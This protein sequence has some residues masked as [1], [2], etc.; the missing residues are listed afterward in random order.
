MSS[1]IHR[2]G[3]SRIWWAVFTWTLLPLLFANS[4][5]SNSPKT[6]HVGILI[7]AEVYRNL[8]EPFK[9]R[10]TKLGYIEGK[11]IVYDEE[12][13]NSDP[14]EDQ[15]IA[16]KFIADQVDL[17]Y[18]FP[19]FAA[20][21][22]KPALQGT[23]IPLVFAMASIEG[24]TLVDSVR[25]PGRNITGVRVPGIEELIKCFESLIEFSPPI[26]KVMVIYDPNYATTP[27]ALVALRNA[28]EDSKISLQE[29][30]IP[31][32][33]DTQTILQGLDESGK[34]DMDAIIFLLDA[35]PM[36]ADAYGLVYQFADAHRVP[37]AG[38]PPSSV[39]NGSV[40]TVTTDAI[41]TAELAASQAD[42]VLKGTPAGSIPVLSPKPVLYLNYKKAQELGLTIP[43]GLLKQAVNIIR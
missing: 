40:L 1:N 39:Q 10:M 5:A 4:C 35:I 26:E 37:V 2:E 30:Q 32:I 18:V 17:V 31:R 27:T 14:T 12:R 13:S 6:Y 23:D 8:I 15:R 38:G 7:G 16:A 20:R 33:Q 29:V 28:A 36:S 22:I 24:T 42:Q 34:A 43:Q 41:E 9:T 25:N 21:D 19:G 11:N 3:K